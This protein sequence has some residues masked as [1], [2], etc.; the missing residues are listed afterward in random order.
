MRQNTT[1]RANNNGGYNY[2]RQSISD[3]SRVL[4]SVLSHLLFA[5]HRAFIISEIRL[6]PAAVIPPVRLGFAD[7][8][9]VLALSAAYR[10]LI[11]SEILFLAAALIRRLFRPVVAIV[12]R[13]SLSAAPAPLLSSRL[14]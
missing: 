4:R 12:L 9:S 11:P 14:I 2:G 1:R 13:P 8:F 5:A 6:R 7:G 3:R 10:R